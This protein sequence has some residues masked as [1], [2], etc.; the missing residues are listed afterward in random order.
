VT[1]LLPPN[2]DLNLELYALVNDRMKMDVV[3]AALKHYLE[4][5]GIKDPLARPTLPNTKTNGHN[6]V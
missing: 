2:L 6:Q 3:A 1:L 5:N 4:S